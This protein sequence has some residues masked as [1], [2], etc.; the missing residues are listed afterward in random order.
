MRFARQV[1][2]LRPRASKLGY[3]YC[4]WRKCS[5]GGQ[6]LTRHQVVFLQIR[7]C[8]Q[9]LHVRVYMYILES[10]RVCEVGLLRFGR[11]SRMP[12]TR[13]GCGRDRVKLRFDNWRGA[14]SAT[15]VALH[16][17]DNIFAPM[18]SNESPYHLQL[19]RS[20]DG[21]CWGGLDGRRSCHG[22]FV[23]YVIDT[24]IRLLPLPPSSL[25]YTSSPKREVP[26]SAPFR[27]LSTP[28]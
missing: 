20:P 6:R 2:L 15:S 1:I 16:V 23:R 7:C 8:V 12:G 22:A 18:Y 27:Y 3:M 17:Y 10:G 4:T 28:I 14:R 5:Y 24:S 26:S 19:Q 25:Q 9:G 11:R 13:F 21:V